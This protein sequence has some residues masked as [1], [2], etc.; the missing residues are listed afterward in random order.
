LIFLVASTPSILGIWAS[1]MTISGS[2]SFSFS[3]AS[4]PSPSAS[5]KERSGSLDMDRVTTAGYDVY[6]QAIAEELGEEVSL[7]S[8]R[9]LNNR[10]EQDRRGI[11]QRYYCLRGFK[12]FQAASRF[13]SAFDELRN[14]LRPQQRM[15]EAASLTERRK[16][17][18]ERI[19]SLKAMS[20]AA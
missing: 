20:Q 12:G 2:N 10:S 19:G 5:S 15:E 4:R 18:L 9:Y 7:R 3:T 11:K 14:Y 8:N 13:C 1:M 16:V 6:P 17:H